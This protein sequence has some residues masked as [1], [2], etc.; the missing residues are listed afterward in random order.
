[1]SDQRRGV[2]AADQ[3]GNLPNRVVTMQGRAADVAVARAGEQHDRGLDPA[4]QP[5]GDAM[6][7]AD[8]VVRKM[9]REPVRGRN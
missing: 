8:A 6:T 3:R 5:H 2:H 9:R 7:R 4:R 1:L